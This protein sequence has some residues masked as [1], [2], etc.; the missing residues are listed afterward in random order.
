MYLQAACYLVVLDKLPATGGHGGVIAV[1][2]DGQI[3]WSFNT[4]GMYRARAAEG[5]AL[6]VGIYKDE[7]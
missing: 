1:A 5:Q 6:S 7:P 2:P 3:A 4:T